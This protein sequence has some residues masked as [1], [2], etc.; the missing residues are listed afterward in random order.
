VKDNESVKRVYFVSIY[1]ITKLNVNKFPN[2][3][4]IMDLNKRELLAHCCMH[5][6]MISER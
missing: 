5:M 3:Y 4:V 2:P 1:Y 6:V